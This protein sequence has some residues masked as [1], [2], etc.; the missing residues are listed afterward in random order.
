MNLSERVLNIQE[1]ETLAMA[2][3]ARELQ[4]QGHD[5]VNLSLGEPDFDTPDFIKKAAIK[6]LEDNITKYP[7]VA[8][9]QDLREA[10]CLKFKRDNNLTYKPDQIVV[11]TGAKQSIANICLSILNPGDEVILPAPYWV[12]YREIVKLCGAIPVSIASSVENSFKI[13]ASELRKAITPKTKLLIFSA[14]SNPTGSFYTEQELERWVEVLKEYPQILVLSDEIYEHI[15]FYSK[16]VSIAQFPEIFDRVVV[17][18]GVSKAFAMTGWRIGYMAGPK[19]LADACS[20]V[21]GQF[22]SGANT[23]AQKAATAALIENPYVIKPM[24]EEFHKRR[25][26]IISLLQKNQHLKL[27]SPQAAFYVFPD[28]SFYF[29]KKVG[30]TLIQNSRDLSMY[31]LYEAYVSTVP[32]DAFESPNNIRLSFATS[33][34]NIEK[35]IER[36][37]L[38]LEKLS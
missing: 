35:A 32:G 27:F 37:N 22:T 14:P 5:V 36:M 11:S 24:V 31:L 25:D 23:I 33:R 3:L 20:N 16:H 28:V 38:A 12:T 1:P 10:I 30:N 21:Q 15:N 19:W 4:S 34:L 18:N 6:A 13:S 9:F 29:G 17:V 2:R 26:L 7:P 8:G